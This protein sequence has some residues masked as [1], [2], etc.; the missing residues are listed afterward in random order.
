MEQVDGLLPVSFAFAAGA[1]LALV[2]SDVLPTAYGGRDRLS[3]S[4][5]FGLGASLMLA[6]SLALGV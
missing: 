5:G 3:P 1:M 4:L 2:L 6:L